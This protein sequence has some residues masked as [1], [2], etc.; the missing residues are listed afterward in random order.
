M[1]YLQLLRLNYRH[2]GFGL[3][4]YFYSLPGQSILISLFKPHFNERL[5]TSDE[6]FGLIY[7][8][9]TMLSAF[10]LP[11]VGGLV[12]RYRV[13]YLSLVNGVLLFLFTW[14]I[15]FTDH[16]L[17][18][19]IGLYG[20]R[21]C[22]QGMMV[23]IATTAISR[24]FDT[25][26]GKALSLSGLGLS[27]G[28][29][30]MPVIVVSLI[31]GFDW[32]MAWRILG[33]SVLLVFLPLMLLTVH[34]RDP[35]QLLKIDKD[36][37]EKGER[38]RSLTRKEVLRDKRF[39]YLLF[40]AIFPGFLLTGLFVHQDLVAA[41][42]GWSLE[43]MA[44]SFL[45][46]GLVKILA[47]FL[48]GPMV[49]RYTARRIFPYFL[50]PLC[51]GMLVLLLFSHPVAAVIYLALAGIANALSAI[52][53]SAIWAELYGVRNLGAIKSALS[54]FG[55]AGTAIGAVLFGWLLKHEGWVPYTY[56]GSILLMLLVS[57][58][59][60]RALHT[61]GSPS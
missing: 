2:I 53:G 55:V 48:I 40:P 3:L 30:F 52:L 24:F 18:L 36:A 4:H 19:F 21:F 7:S 11:F 14:L 39:Y 20:L 22:G 42:Q 27:L 13:R 31:D 38:E 28:E 5:N 17:I 57:Y 12:D 34:S 49:D 26:R 61:S 46:F 50:L 51:G 47:Y 35:F 15:S 6:E 25:E 45:A 56:M 8:I 16:W 23:L 9:A 60:Y 10:T 41:W 33:A 29:A 59:A 43:W 44:T 58:G 1:N 54:T 37:E 32:Q